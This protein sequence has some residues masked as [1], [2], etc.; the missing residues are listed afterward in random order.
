MQYKI[1]SQNKEGFSLKE[2]SRNEEHF[3]SLVLF[4]F[5]SGEEGEEGENGWSSLYK[6][7]F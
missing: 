1:D 2:K 3:P 4:L 7:I 6:E 5:L